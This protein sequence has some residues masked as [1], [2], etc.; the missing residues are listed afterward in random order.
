[1]LQLGRGA[2]APTAGLFGSIGDSAPDTWGRRLMQRAECRG[3]EREART[4]RTLTELD[5]L[6]GVSDRARLGALRFCRAGQDSFL[7]GE[8][9]G[10]P[11][12][13]D[14]GS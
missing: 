4:P 8:G 14:L 1:M 3:A 5:Y 10:V 12:L 9:V 7:A 11:G 2:F 6:L 13:V